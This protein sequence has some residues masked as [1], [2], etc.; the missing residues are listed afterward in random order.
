LRVGELLQPKVNIIKLAETMMAII[1][2]EGA[3]FEVVTLPF[4]HGKIFG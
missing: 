2:T 3:V 1:F 4:T